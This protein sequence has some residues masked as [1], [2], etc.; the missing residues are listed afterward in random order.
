[1]AISPYL[2]LKLFCCPSVFANEQK[3]P[4]SSGQRTLKQKQKM[5]CQKDISKA[6]KK[7]KNKS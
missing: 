5:I 4:L 7:Y 2:P 3:P 6:L 1:M